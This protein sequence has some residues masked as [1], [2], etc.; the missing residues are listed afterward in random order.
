MF[1]DDAT[2]GEA[3]TNGQD[4]SGAD[5][6]YLAGAV[7]YEEGIE[8]MEEYFRAWMTTPC[9]DGRPVARLLAQGL[10]DQAHEATF[11]DDLGRGAQLLIV[12]EPFMPAVSSMYFPRD[13]LRHVCEAFD[14]E[15]FWETC[16]EVIDQYD[17]HNEFVACTAT[18][19]GLRCFSIRKRP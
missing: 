5:P 6:D 10:Y 4:T 19:M 12:W 14:M 1:S 17:P 15:P 3:Q 8:A 9:E 2:N 11:R 16:R 13:A 7:S 18:Y